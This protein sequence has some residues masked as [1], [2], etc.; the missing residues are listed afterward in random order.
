MQLEHEKLKQQKEFEI[1]LELEKMKFK[2][3]QTKL[4]LEQYKLNLIKEGKRN[5]GSGRD[6]VVASET[7]PRCDIST[8]LKLVPKF[9]E[10]DPDTFFSLFERVAETCEW[11]DTERT[12][13]LQCVFTG[14]AQEAFSALSRADSK[15]Y[16]KVKAAVLKA[17][18]LVPEAYRQR[19]R[20]FRKREHQTYVEFVRDMVLQFNRWCSASEVGTFEQLCDLVALE[21]VKNCVPKNVATY[22]NE[23]K[24]KTPQEAAVLA[25]EYILIHK[26]TF[27]KDSVDAQNTSAC[28]DKLVLLHGESSSSRVDRSWKKRDSSKIC[29]YCQHKGHWKNDCPVLKG[30][31]KF[32]GSS[33]VKPAALAASVPS[34]QMALQINSPSDDLC[35]VDKSKGDD[36][37]AAFIS[38]GYV[39]LVGEKVAVKILRDTGAKHSFVCESVLPFAADSNTG[40]FILMRGMGM[41]IIPVPVHKMELACGLVTGEV[42]VGVR[43]ALPVEGIDMILGNDLAGNRVWAD[44]PPPYVITQVPVLPP[45]QTDV[46]ESVDLPEVGLFPV[47][48]VTRAMGRG[49]DEAEKQEVTESAKNGYSG[50]S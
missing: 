22:L 41:T 38:D 47:C 1:Q 7:F 34:A 37:F 42:A 18:E 29:N 14:K 21:Q 13:L 40:N 23:Q 43:P 6:S 3:E 11:P 46:L 25:D 28:T 39:S 32:S 19:F 16:V 30:R 35:P 5:D 45:L 15:V 33:Q 49:K 9:S 17:Y 26:G 44:V 12:L 50:A 2:T 36:D 24:V 48:A 10:K 20:S 31:S 8:K 27:C 4:E